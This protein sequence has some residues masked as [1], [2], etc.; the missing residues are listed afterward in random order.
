[1]DRCMPCTRDGAIRAWSG[2]PPCMGL[3]A[4]PR[5]T[6][7]A[8]AAA[9]GHI[10]PWLPHPERGP[11]RR[12]PTFVVNDLVHG[13]VRVALG[14]GGMG[15][16][17]AGAGRGWVCT[18]RES[19]RGGGGANPDRSGPACDA[20]PRP[21][22]LWAAAHPSEAFLGPACVW[23]GA[24]ALGPPPFRARPTTAGH[25]CA[26]AAS[27]ARRRRLPPPRRPAGPPAGSPPSS[28]SCMATPAS[29]AGD[30]GSGCS[31]APGCDGRG[32]VIATTSRV[33]SGCSP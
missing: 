25:A 8:P 23:A 2:L 14:A 7:L 29:I 32:S 12:L 15:A 6:G 24:R 1:M 26:A 27:C 21:P 17:R 20:G 33:F 31:Q 30:A 19:R 3:G 11:K 4:A 10:A 16:R 9:R 28:A 18:S 22:P 13:L 5:Q